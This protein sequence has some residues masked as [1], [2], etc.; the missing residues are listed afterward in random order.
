[1]LKLINKYNQY[2]NIYKAKGITQR[3]LFGFVLSI[4]H[5]LACL[6]VTL[7]FPQQWIGIF[8]VG[9][10]LPDFSLFAYLAILP[11]KFDWA[12]DNMKKVAHLLTFVLIIFL[13]I[14]EAYVL[15]LAGSIHLL[16]DFLGF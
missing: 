7:F 14:K 4:P 10:L 16:L 2:F 12:G 8:I 1:M 11:Q 9:W 6:V 15:F 3:V 5:I 13:L